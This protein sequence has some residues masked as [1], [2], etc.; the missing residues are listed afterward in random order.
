MEANAT[1]GVHR[2]EIAEF[3]VALPAAN[4]AIVTIIWVA[5]RPDGMVIWDF[6]D[7]RFLANTTH[8]WRIL[9]DMVHDAD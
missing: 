9:G 5:R 7:T 8:G 4:G 1:E 2:W 3:E 6:K